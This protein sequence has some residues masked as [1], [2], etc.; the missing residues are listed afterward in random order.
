[1]DVPAVH[2]VK[3]TDGYN[4]AYSVAGE[5]QTI[6]AMPYPFSHATLSWTTPGL[7]GGRV[8]LAKKFRVVHFDARGQGLSSRG[9]SD[10]HK[11]EDYLLDMEAVVAGLRLD[12]FILFAGVGFWKAAVAYTA[13]NPHKVSALIIMN[14][15]TTVAASDPSV[16][17]ATQAAS[18][19]DTY[20]LMTGSTLAP[21][22]ASHAE[23]FHLRDL[24]R[25][26]VDKADYLKLL[27]A[28]RGCDASQWLVSI[29]TPTLVVR[30]QSPWDTSVSSDIAAAIP[31][32]EM[33][34]VDD[35]GSV[36]DSVAGAI[37]PG[38]TAIEEFVDSLPASL[39]TEASI[40]PPEAPLSEH[41]IPRVD[42]TP[43]Q[44]EVLQLMSMGKTNREIA[45]EL[46]LSVRTVE[47]HLAEAYAKMGAHNRYEAIAMSS[48]FLTDSHTG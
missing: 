9:L 31:G 37:P 23:R 1:M 2:Y 12:R 30:Q 40:S 11:V 8:A 20:V 28:S 38:V 10:T 42:L 6:L 46:V 29:R 33:R 4:I 36:F 13:M 15:T 39:P 3:T 5:G 25:Q 32:A 27:Y 14:P 47:R 44:V 19:W 26:C 48:S 35:Y 45:D 43:R 17:V 21:G 18:D 34:L 24:M 41:E 7:L 16:G 22:F